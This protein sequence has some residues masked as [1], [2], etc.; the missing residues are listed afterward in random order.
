MRFLGAFIKYRRYSS[1]SA[2][3]MHKVA[4]GSASRRL[5]FMGS[6]H[7]KHSPKSPS[8]IRCRAASIL[9]R[10]SRRSRP[11]SRDIAWACIASIRL[12]RPTRAWS[13]STTCSASPPVS[14]ALSSA[15]LRSSKRFLNC[16]SRLSEKLIRS[17]EYQARFAHR[18][19]F[20]KYFTKGCNHFLPTAYILMS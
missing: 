8:S 18:E 2:H 11:V 17:T 14:S 20:P 19:I 3:F 10:L 13:S 1:A 15:C 4:V 12:R 6:Q 5:G 16:S 9:T 7:S